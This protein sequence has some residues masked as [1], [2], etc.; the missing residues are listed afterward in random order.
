MLTAAG[1]TN[2]AAEALEQALE[3]YERKRNL[4]DASSGSWT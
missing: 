1:K 4:P 2:D 3:H